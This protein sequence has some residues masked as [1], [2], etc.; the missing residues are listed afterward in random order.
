MKKLY[1]R[2]YVQGF[3]YQTTVSKLR[4]ESLGYDSQVY[5]LEVLRVL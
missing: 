4:Y 5:G 2:Y 3:L 1:V